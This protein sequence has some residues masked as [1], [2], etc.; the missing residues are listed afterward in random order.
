MEEYRNKIIEL[1]KEIQYTNIEMLEYIVKT[2]SYLFC[3]YYN[4]SRNYY[5]KCFSTYKN[6]LVYFN[7]NSFHNPTCIA[8]RDVHSF[9]EEELENI[10]N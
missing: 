1:E 5:S 8:V 4:G 9:S 10:D 2:H 3:I 6:A 7:N